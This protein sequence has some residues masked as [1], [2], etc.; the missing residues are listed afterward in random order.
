MADPHALAVTA[1]VLRHHVVGEADKI[2]VLFSREAGVLRVLAKGLRKAGSRVGGRLEAFRECEVTLARGRN[3]PI[4][5]AVD[6]VRRF[7]AINTDYDALAA[8]MAA[9]EVVIALFA[10]DDPQPEAYALFGDFLATLGPDTPAEILLTAFELQLMGLLGYR[11]DLHVCTACGRAITGPREA[12]GLHIEDGGALCA[13]CIEAT[14]GRV[15]RL[16]GAAWGLLVTLQDQPLA[17][18]VSLKAPAGVVASARIALRAY[19]GFRA[20]RE[21][22]AQSMFDWQPGGG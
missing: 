16:T 8:G 5:T 18:C 6:S 7:P 22:K 20:E 10:A 4:V 12:G 9:C 11:P 13:G 15:R 17:A 19:V 14:P 2:V 3:L 1:F 21:L